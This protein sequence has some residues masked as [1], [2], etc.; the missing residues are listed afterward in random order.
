MTALATR[1]AGARTPTNVGL[2]AVEKYL[3]SRL[4]R[5]STR[6]QFWLRERDQ[7]IREAHAAGASLREIAALVDL[8]HVGVKKIIERTDFVPNPTVEEVVAERLREREEEEER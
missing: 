2:V 5:A 6:A 8:S 1:V 3:S 4:R 7:L